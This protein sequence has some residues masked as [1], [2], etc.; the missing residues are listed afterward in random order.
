[1]DTVKTHTHKEK[2]HLVPT[3]D[4]SHSIPQARLRAAMSLAL[5][6][7]HQAFC[8]FIA[9]IVWQCHVPASPPSWTL[10]SPLG[11]PQCTIKMSRS[12]KRE[13]QTEKRL[14]TTMA[15]LGC[16]GDEP[17][18]RHSRRALFFLFSLAWHRMRFFWASGARHSL[19]VCACVP[20]FVWQKKNSRSPS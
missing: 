16:T 19:C 4:P 3:F 8:L 5:F 9:G 11:A 7:P 18:R 1:M 14:S 15:G 17:L 20:V 10:C 6:Y 2:V 13:M 12:K